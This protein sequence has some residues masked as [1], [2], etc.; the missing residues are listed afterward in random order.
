MKKSEIKMLE[1][2]II[3]TTNDLTESTEQFDILTKDVQ[4]VTEIMGSVHLSSVE[5]LKA[6]NEIVNSITNISQS[7]EHIKTQY[8]DVADKLTNIKENLESLNNISVN[9][10]KTMNKLMDIL[11]KNGVTLTMNK[12]SILQTYNETLIDGGID[13]K[14]V[15]NEI[16]IMNQ[17]RDADN[18]LEKVDW[19]IPHARYQLLTLNKALMNH[20]AV[21][22]TLLYNKLSLVLFTPLTFKKNGVSFVD[23]FFMKSPQKFI[24]SE[25]TLVSDKQFKSDKEQNLRQIYIKTAPPEVDNSIL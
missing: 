20:P 23:L 12:E 3:T 22:I 13:V 5:Q 14:S 1:D 7:S 6:I 16:L 25:S 8:I 15:H 18:V 21:T 10:S 11:D 4:E 17:I 19:T 24:N 9:A 2:K